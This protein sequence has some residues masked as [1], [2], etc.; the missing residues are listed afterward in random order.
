MS[1]I[2]GASYALELVLS[3]YGGAMSSPFRRKRGT[4]TVGVQVNITP[5]VKELIDSYMAAAGVPQ[6]AVV[7]AAIRAGQPDES[8]I[9]VGWDLP[10]HPRLDMDEDQHRGGEPMRRTA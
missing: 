6:W 3:K 10:R 9:P 1:N 5:D 7:E 2:P 4:P 8:G